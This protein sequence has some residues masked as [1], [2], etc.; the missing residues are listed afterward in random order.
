MTIKANYT[1]E[2]WELIT[3]DPFMAAMAVVAASPSVPVGVVKE[4]LAVGSVL[5]EWSG[6]GSTADDASG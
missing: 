4:M 3:R 2:E 6:E 1:A 5:A